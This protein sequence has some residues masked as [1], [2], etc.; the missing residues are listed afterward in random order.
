LTQPFLSHRDGLVFFDG[1]C[2]AVPFLV[3][4]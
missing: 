4:P 2:A 1:G 3:R